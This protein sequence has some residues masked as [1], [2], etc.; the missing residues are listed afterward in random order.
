MLLF[1]VP[2]SILDMSNKD[3]LM[4]T[5]LTNDLSLTCYDY[6]NYYNETGSYE[7]KGI[8]AIAAYRAYDFD[9]SAYDEPEAYRAADLS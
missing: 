7:N 1:S 8:F 2:D 9:R 4:M 6:I 5:V 3:T